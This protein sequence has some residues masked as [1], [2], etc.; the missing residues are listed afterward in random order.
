ML[1]VL[2]KSL[3]IRTLFATILLLIINLRSASFL[4]LKGCHDDTFVIKF[5]QV[6]SFLVA[7]CSFF[8]RSFIFYRSYVLKGH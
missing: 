3:Y 2:R 4:Q 7:N 8:F 6:L 1:G 5:D